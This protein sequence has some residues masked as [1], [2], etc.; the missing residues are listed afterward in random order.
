MMNIIVK[1]GL[2]VLGVGV[3]AGVAAAV[4]HD[5]HEEKAANT[6]IRFAIDDVVREELKAKEKSRQEKSIVSRIKRFVIKK[7][8]KVLSFVIIHKEQVEAVGAIMGLVSAA[9]SISKSVKDFVTEDVRD[10]QL[11]EMQATLDELNHNFYGA[12]RAQTHNTQVE[13]VALQHIAEATKCDMDK[14]MQ[15]LKDIR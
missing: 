12:C 14:L 9:I 7:F 5:N 1:V 4:V 2:G 3:V 8:I 15:D 13:C 11:E 6:A 10:G